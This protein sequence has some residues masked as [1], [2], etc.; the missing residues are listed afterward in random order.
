M[1][2]V[3]CYHFLICDIIIEMLFKNFDLQNDYI[4]QAL[5]EE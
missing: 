3:S 4:K 1:G 2:F 5:P